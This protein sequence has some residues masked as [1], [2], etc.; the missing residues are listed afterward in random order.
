MSKIRKSIA[1]AYPTST[2]AR[3]LC[4]PGYFVSQYRLLEDGT[5]SAPYIAQGHDVFTDRNDPELLALFEET[6][7]EPCPYFIQSLTRK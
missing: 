7:G 1:Y 4:S 6:D 5:W 2:F 3:E